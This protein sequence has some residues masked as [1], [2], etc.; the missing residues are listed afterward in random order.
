MFVYTD[1]IPIPITV[2]GFLIAIRSGNR[3][4]WVSLAVD[5]RKCRSATSQK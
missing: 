5:S 1:I 3:F 4:T 2:G